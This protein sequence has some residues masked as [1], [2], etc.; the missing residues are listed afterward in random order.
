[1]KIKL[2]LI[3]LLTFQSIYCQTNYKTNLNLL[4]NTDFNISYPN[5]LKLDESGKKG[6][7]FILL[8]E[9][10]NSKDDFIENINLIIQ[11]L[12]K[13]EINLDKYVTIS[14]KQIIDVGK[15][16]ES[17]RIVKNNLE[18]QRVIFEAFLNNF[19]LKFLQYYFVKNNKAFVLTFSCKKEEFN[20]YLDD[21][22]NVM[23]SFSLN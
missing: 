8:S 4:R 16:S 17:N 19:D 21:M 10:I 11:D 23:R 7:V 14:E 9:K 1:M 5:N 13:L 6:T 15:L 3:S 12:S 18:F 22:E 20:K 2:I